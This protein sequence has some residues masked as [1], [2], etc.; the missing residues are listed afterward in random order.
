MHLKPINGPYWG[1]ATNNTTLTPK[2]HLDPI[3][4]PYWGAGPQNRASAPFRA[5]QGVLNPK[6][7]P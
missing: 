2:L 6:T 3:N 7:A 5:T 4:S 1:A